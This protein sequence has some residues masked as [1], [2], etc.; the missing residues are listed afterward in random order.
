MLFYLGTGA[1]NV[2]WH[3]FIIKGEQERVVCVCW[4]VLRGFLGRG[5]RTGAGVQWGDPRLIHQQVTET[6]AGSCNPARMSHLSVWYHLFSFFLYL[7]IFWIRTTVS[8]ER[9]N[10]DYGYENGLF[11]TILHHIYLFYCIVHFWVELKACKWRCFSQMH[12]VS[13]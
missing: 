10:W 3:L 9:K 2:H 4:W 13:L 7:F 5:W 6:A 8:H 11:L 1:G 12:R